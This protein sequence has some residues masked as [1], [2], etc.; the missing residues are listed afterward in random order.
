MLIPRQL[1]PTVGLA[2]G[3]VEFLKG[4]HLGIDELAISS[5]EIA[6]R[7]DQVNY[8]FK[9]SRLVEVAET[10]DASGLDARICDHTCKRPDG[11][12]SM[13]VASVTWRFDGLAQQRRS[14]FSLSR[15][16]ANHGGGCANA[17][18]ISLTS[19]LCTPAPKLIM[20]QIIKQRTCRLFLIR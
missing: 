5:D 9:Y 8:S 18:L 3:G 14:I 20:F 2:H 15:C 12:A 19:I 11:Y 4:S 10:A 6:L 13:F 1:A 7:F 17:T 16:I